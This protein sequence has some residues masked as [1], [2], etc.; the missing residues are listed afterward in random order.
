LGP[1]PASSPEDDDDDDE[2]DDDEEDDDEED[3]ELLL[4]L[5]EDALPLPP[6]DFLVGAS[7]WEASGDAWDPAGSRSGA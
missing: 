5:G 3:K 7:R 4:G 1:A 6:T 2:D